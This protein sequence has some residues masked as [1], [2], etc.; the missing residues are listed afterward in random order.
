MTKTFGDYEVT[1]EKP[2][3]SAQ[4]MSIGNQTL[5]FTIK[6]AKT[7][8]PIKTLKPYLGAFGH[9]VMINSDNYAYLHVH[10]KSATPPLPD[11]NGGPT[12]SFLPLGLYGPIK[13]GIYRVFAQFNPDNHLFT[14]DFTVKVE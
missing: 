7:H 9:L 6:D 2:E 1:L 12:V 5:S 13:P 8:Q 10:P 14:A 3:L 4:E 11:Q